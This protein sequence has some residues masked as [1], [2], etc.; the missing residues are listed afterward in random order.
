MLAA[1]SGF[2]V[3]RFHCEQNAANLRAQN[4]GGLYET[5]LPTR[6]RG[7]VEAVRTEF[8]GRNAQV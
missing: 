5:I 7:F 2:P 4:T 8:F 3:V 1:A 6:K